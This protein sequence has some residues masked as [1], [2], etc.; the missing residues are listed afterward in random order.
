MNVES[1]PI[2]GERL[3]AVAIDRAGSSKVVAGVLF[4]VA[5]VCVIAMLG[6]LTDGKK[7]DRNSAQ[8]VGAAIGMLLVVGVPTLF[9]IRSLRN[10]QRATRASNVAKTDPGYTWRLSG[11][12]LIAVDPSGAPRPDVSF[13]LDGKLRAML[14]AMPRADAAAPR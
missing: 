13:K 9:A 4:F 1:I 12:Q 6:S 8:A 2:P 10:A 14:L 11:K 3:P 5:A 7:K